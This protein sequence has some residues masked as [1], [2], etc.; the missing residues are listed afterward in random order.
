MFP[1]IFYLKIVFVD[2]SS[3][4]VVIFYLILN[5]IDKNIRDP[6]NKAIMIRDSD[7]EALVEKNQKLK[8][9]INDL[10]LLGRSYANCQRWP[11][12]DM[13]NP[14]KFTMEDD[15]LYLTAFQTVIDNSA[16]EWIEQKGTFDKLF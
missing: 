8:D 11:I 13:K 1:L 9:S 5:I 15:E 4:I 14:L 2:L 16:A 12:D 3:A 7:F 6:I 10:C